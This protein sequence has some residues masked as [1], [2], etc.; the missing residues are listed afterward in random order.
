MNRQIYLFANQ[1]K[2]T[3]TQPYSTT[4]TIDRDYVQTTQGRLAYA[5]FLRGVQA[6]DCG[7]NAND[8]LDTC[9]PNAVIAN[10]Q[11]N[12][13]AQHIADQDKSGWSYTVSSGSFYSDLSP[14]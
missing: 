2:T 11:V 3:M 14:Y 4:C 12:Q 8:N 5:N 9:D 13:R 10:Y 7:C 6:T 1:N